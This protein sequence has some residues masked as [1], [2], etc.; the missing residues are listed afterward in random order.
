MIPQEPER[1]DKAADAVHEG[2]P[3]DAE[4]VRSGRKNPRIAVILA[5]STLAAAV[6]LLGLWFVTNGAFNAK[7][8]ETGPQAAA[9]ETQAFAGDS[10]TPP[11]AD[12]PTD[13]TGRAVATP[14]GEAP[15]VNAPTVPSN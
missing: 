10:Q 7:N 6:L 9:A 12:A 4:L 2:R 15:N 1:H 13:S 5:V 14:T 8:A 3:V 11:A